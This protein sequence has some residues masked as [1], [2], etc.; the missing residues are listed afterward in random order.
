VTIED[1]KG[2]HYQTTLDFVFAT[3]ETQSLISLPEAGQVV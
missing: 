1:K 3:G 2:N